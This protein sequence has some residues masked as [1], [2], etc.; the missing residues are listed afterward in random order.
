MEGAWDVAVDAQ[1]TNEFDVLIRRNNRL[2]L[3]SCK[4]ADP[5]RRTEGEA[6]A[7]DFLYELDSL[8][9]RA[10]GLFGGRMLASAL[11]VEDRFVRE[12]A[13]MMGIRIVSG[14]DA[15]ALRQALAEW[16]IGPGD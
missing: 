1:P 3:V 15:A 8:A 5:S 9:D 6:V 4:T 13:T 10:L 2:F 14:L 11:P 16:I 7:K 12:R